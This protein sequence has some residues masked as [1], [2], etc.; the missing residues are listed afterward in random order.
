MCTQDLQR[1]KL[2]CPQ[3]VSGENNLV[4]KVLLEWRYHNKLIWMHLKSLKEVPW[5]SGKNINPS[6]GHSVV[7]KTELHFPSNSH[8]TQKCGVFN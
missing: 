4:L 6:T 5:Y 8:T 1:A 3:C 7:E 2:I